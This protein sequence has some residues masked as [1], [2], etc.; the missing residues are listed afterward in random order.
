MAVSGRVAQTVSTL[1][2]SVA[3]GSPEDEAVVLASRTHRDR[4]PSTT[5]LR[6]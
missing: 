5:T 6:E 2:K 4:G 3:R 1:V